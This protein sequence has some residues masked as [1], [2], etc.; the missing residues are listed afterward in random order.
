MA[1]THL[2]CYRDFPVFGI[3]NAHLSYN[4]QK[5]KVLLRLSM[6]TKN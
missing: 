6:L 4:E 1:V 5:E 3:S 2:E